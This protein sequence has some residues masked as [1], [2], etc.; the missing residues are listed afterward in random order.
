MNPVT[1]YLS[2]LA[3]IRSSGYA[4]NETSYYPAIE[5]LL[6]EVGKS[7]KPRV[8]PVLQLKNRGAGQ[9]DGGLFTQDQLRRGVDAHVIDFAVEP[10]NRGAVEVKGL[11]ESL[12]ETVKGEQ[13]AK[14]L[15]AYGQVLVTNYRDFRIVV[16]G[17]DGKATVLESYSVAAS[18]DAFWAAAAHPQ[19]MTAEHGAHLREFLTRAMLSSVTIS[20]PQHLA[21][22]MASYARDA[23]AKVEARAQLKELAEVRKALEEA[24]GLKIIDE[25]GEHFFRSTLVQTL[26]CPASAGNGE[27]VRPLR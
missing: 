18:E 27:S 11:G 6:A 25:K 13:V 4:T 14:Y 26:F 19:K 23:L 22:F 17:Q 9:P 2:K 5:T 16:K 10:P 20:S 21:G 1:D 8:K 12:S 15:R 3:E 24:L 7:L